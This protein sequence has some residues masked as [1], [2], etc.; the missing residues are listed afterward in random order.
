MKKI[1]SIISGSF[2][3][4]MLVLLFTIQVAAAENKK[5]TAYEISVS[6]PASATYVHIDDY[7]ND[8]YEE[9]S[10]MWFKFT[11]PTS[12]YYEFE[13]V[14]GNEDFEIY[15]Y[16]STGSFVGCDG[17]YDSF[18]ERVIDVINCKAGNTYYL[19]VCYDGDTT[20][21]IKM[22]VKKHSHTYETYESERATTYYSGY[23]I[24]ECSACYKKIKTTYY[25]VKTV[26][27]SYTSCTYN[28]KTKSP[29][30]TVADS[31]G[32]NLKLNTDY[33]ISGTTSAKDIGKY[34]IKITLTGHY[35]GSTTLTY[36]I[37]P[38]APANISCSKKTDSSVT[39]K[40]DKV[41]KA[42]SYKIY[43]YDEDY[44]DY[45][46]QKTVTGNTA[47]IYQLINC[48][49]YKF[50]VSAVTKNENGAVAGN[51][52][53]VITVTTKPECPSTDVYSYRTGKA[54]IEIYNC[55][56]RTTG[57]KIYMATSK[58]GEYKS[59]KTINDIAAY[60]DFK[61]TVSNLKSGKYYY[62]KVKSFYVKNNVTIYS[63]YS[64]TERV[65]VE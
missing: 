60:K 34:S 38:A 64:S 65:K 57:F 26:K 6:K 13:V 58:D 61:T 62:F 22:A 5:S 32:N 17:G 39:L 42:T 37:R 36:Y 12:D 24:K 43:M 52:S 48:S 59:V 25:T 15:S 14:G 10:V 50:K 51:M 16:N 19:K 28:G 3:V 21:T 54:E 30:I 56:I 29:K 49:N 31:K 53:K 47:T 7:E 23:E 55:N 44:S 2:A 1:I 33:K 40:W 41:D 35:K 9:D 4:I 46:Y 20:K 45:C 63:G 18:F 27:L 11:A 8:I